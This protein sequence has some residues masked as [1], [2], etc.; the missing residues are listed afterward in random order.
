MRV[1]LCGLVLL[2]GC[3]SAAPPRPFASTLPAFRYGSRFVVVGDLQRTSLLE[4]WRESNDAERAVLVRAIAELHPA[5]V[6]MTGDMVFD[7]SS[8]KKWSDFDELCT[9]LR[10]AGVPVVAAFGNH[11]YWGGREG[12]AQVFARV[13][14]LGGR[15]WYTV[16]YG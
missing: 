15:H 9:P 4:F 12:E 11:E 5:F 7:G 1:F 10:E 6:A 16:A 2:T 14:T 3:A 8:K 13:P